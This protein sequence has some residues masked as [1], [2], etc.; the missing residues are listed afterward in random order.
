MEA[1]NELR[2]IVGQIVGADRQS[3]DWADKPNPEKWSKKEVL[4]HLVDSAL[5]NL[6]RFVRCTYEE[7]FKLVYQQVEW[8]QAQHYQEADIDELFA[9]W[10][11][12]NLQIAHVLDNYPA[13]RLHVKCDN[14]KNTV[15]FHTVEWLA[16]DYLAHLKHH[17]SQVYSSSPAYN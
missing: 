11:S 13:E 10:R 3:I 12:L 8:V 1:A 9:L 16:E 7:N 4:G 2:S 15:S 17:L 14:S 6:H 5:N